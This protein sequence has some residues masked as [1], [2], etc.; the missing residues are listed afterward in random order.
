MKTVLLII[1]VIFLAIAA[2]G[3]PT[4]IGVAIYNFAFAD[5]GIAIALWEGFKT[6]AIMLGC[7]LVIGYP[8]FFIGQA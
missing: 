4:G 6:W 8:L 5:V 1:G 2:L 7:G 3:I